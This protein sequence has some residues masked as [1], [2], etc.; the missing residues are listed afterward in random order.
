MAGNADL[1]FLPIR[2]PLIIMSA[3][4]LFFREYVEAG[5]PKGKCENHHDG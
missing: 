2:A 3:F 4:L 5:K 1:K